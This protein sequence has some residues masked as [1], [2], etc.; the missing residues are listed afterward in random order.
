[1]HALY[2][3]LQN[4][5]TRERDAQDRT[6]LLQMFPEL[7]SSSNPR[8]LALR[9]YVS[10]RP[11]TFFDRKACEHYL[12]WL[13]ARNTSHS[14][15]LSQYMCEARAEFN[16]AL[17]FLQSINAEDWHDV[18][19]DQVNEYELVRF[20]DKHIHPNYLRLIEAVLFPLTRLVAF[21][22]RIDR[23]KGT[24]GLDVWRV[25]QELQGGSSECLMQNYRHIVRNGIAHGGIQFRHGEITY[26]DKKGNEETLGIR[27]VIALFDSLLDTCNGLVAALKV[28]WISTGARGYTP[29]QHFLVEELQEYTWCPW[30][31]IEGCVESEI[32]GK[33]QLII[34]AR[35]RTRDYRKVQWS[36]ITSGI[37][38]EAFAPGYDRY[39]LSLRSP[40][41]WPG[42]AAFDGRKLRELREQ[43]IDDISKYAGILEDTGVFYVA[44][45]ALPALVGKME[46]LYWS[47][48]TH[49]PLAFQ[50]IRENVGIPKLMCRNAQV[51]RNSWG[52]V[53]NGDV[54]LQGVEDRA[55]VDVIRKH[56]ARI[57]RVAKRHARSENRRSPSAYLPIG[58]AQISV[59]RTDYRRRRLLSFGLGK[60]LIC[61]V[62][63]K[64]IR[65]I[66]S[67][68]ILGSTVETEGNWRI[69]WNRAWLE[70]AG[71]TM[72]DPSR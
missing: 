45:P 4:P 34:Y 68:D 70:D 35:P 71:V 50:Q 24:D 28:F 30:W 36:A 65:R 19:I 18:R 31:S 25:M 3:Q 67:P 2:D 22:S 43:G 6:R 38:A 49:L 46:T 69:A 51:H 7:A 61:T 72:P 12:R 55:V 53:L 44:Q 29:C 59:F 42:W 26:Q 1:M 8:F 57:I 23:A 17:I 13:Q 20:I 41:A 64:R 9:K 37:L 32:P 60:D 27:E 48:R 33:S 10:N 5:L 66:R 58:Y 15:E 39:F 40:V 21:F 52:A 62:R 14:A 63:L 54:L 56:K 11:E 16:R 47:F